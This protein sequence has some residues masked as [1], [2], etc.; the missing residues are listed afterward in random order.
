[1]YMYI[2]SRKS[3][4]S[5]EINL[6]GHQLNFAT[7]CKYLGNVISNNLLDESDIQA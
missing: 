4:L 6:G 2:V 7:Y 5:K 3:N 1:M